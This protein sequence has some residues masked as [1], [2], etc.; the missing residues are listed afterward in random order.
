VFFLARF[1]TQI[2]HAWL[3][4]KWPGWDWGISVLLTAALWPLA[5]WVLHL[6]QRGADDAESSSA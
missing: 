2:I 1:L 4:G 6:P 3:A 5:G